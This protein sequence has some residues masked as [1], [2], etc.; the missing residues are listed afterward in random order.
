MEESQEIL[1]S[2]LAS[3]GVSI[4]TSVSSI[5]DLT[6]TSLFSICAQSLSLIDN[7]TSFP[8]SLPDSMAERFKI[9]TEIA[10]AVKSLG[11]IGDMSFHKFLYPSEEDL[12]KLVRFLVE[13]LPE[14][15]EGGKTAGGNDIR[16]R[17]KIKEDDLPSTSKHWTEKPDNQGVDLHFPNVG[18]KLK[19]LR[20]KSEVQESSDNEAENESG[21]RANKAYSIQQKMDGVAVVDVSIPG[22]QDLSKKELN[23]LENGTGL[24]EKSEDSRR[25]ASRNEE[26]STQRDDKNVLTS[27]QEQS[28]KVKSRIEMLR[29][30]EKLLIEEVTSKN[31]ESQHLEEEYN[32]LK[33]AMEMEFDDQHPVDLYIEQL[34]ERIE[35]GK[36][37]LVELESQ[38]ETLR[39][40]LE[41]KK[42]SLEGSVYATEEEHSKL[43]ADLEKQPK[44]PSRRSYIQRITEITKNSRKQDA[45]IERILKDTRELQLESNSVQERHHRT[46]AVVDET[47]FREAKKDPL[48]RQAY[49]LLTSIHESFEQIAEKILATDRTRREVTEHEAKLAAMASRS[50][51]INKLQADLDAI[52]QENEC[53][54]QR[55]QDD[56]LDSSS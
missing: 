27:F 25:D 14:S 54:E 17:E 44:L 55:L 37:N 10:S 52:R 26:M 20:L 9:C 53:L 6:P 49:M 56:S 7:T 4:P 21:T 1:L 28:L 8:T 23:S 22:T 3:A 15:S 46:Y 16:A 36:R 29:N 2:S 11:Y 41:E 47:I 24:V 51:N 5:Q 12:Y 50:L 35:A 30:Q 34:N 48:G 33:S 45:D 40:P 39:K 43:S 38:W 18:A 19:D 31:L 42:R 32:L 13:K